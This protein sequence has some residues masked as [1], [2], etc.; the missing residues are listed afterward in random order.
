MQVKYL[1]ANGWR[2]QTLFYIHAKKSPFGPVLLVADDKNRIA[3]LGFCSETQA[4][5]EITALQ[6]KWQC[7]IDPK[8][9]FKFLLDAVFAQKRSVTLALVGTDFQ[10]RVWRALLK[11]KN[12]K[13][14][15]YG[16][17]AEQ[18]GSHPRAVGGAVAANPISYLVP[19]HRILAADGS[20]R[21]YRWGLAVKQKLLTA[22]AD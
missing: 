18:M 8:P 12:G 10:Q 1:A 20:L 4:R 9:Q 7:R 19:C 17:L 2:G 14:S 13:K 6:K 21:G 22:E 5:R 3:F 15:T 16:A 11:I